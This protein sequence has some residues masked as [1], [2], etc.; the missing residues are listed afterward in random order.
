[1]LEPA[2]PSEPEPAEPAAAAPPPDAP[3]ITD[4]GAP[5][6]PATI[7]PDE[8]P[9]CVALPAL[10]AL[11]GS[12]EDEHELASP[13]NTEAPTNR[14]RLSSGEFAARTIFLVRDGERR[15]ESGMLLI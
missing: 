5:L 12:D 2:I 3:A 11:P 7:A 15:V 8:P 10:A 1:M 13:A 14:R 9:P 4:A 6:S